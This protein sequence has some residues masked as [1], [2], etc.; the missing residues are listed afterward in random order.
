VTIPPFPPPDPAQRATDPAPRATDPEPLPTTWRAPDAASRATEAPYGSLDYLPDPRIRWGLWAALV[1]VLVFP[2]SMGILIVLV[3]TGIVPI[4]PLTDLLAS[5]A[6]YLIGAAAVVA[7]VR[8]RG[9]GSPAAD[10]GLR[11]RWIDLAIG[12]GTGIGMRVLVIALL[13]PFTPLLEDSQ[14]NLPVY[15][16]LAWTVA[17]LVV[18]GMIGAPLVEELV[19][20]GL[21]MR[22]VRN[23]MLRTRPGGALPDRRRRRLA[24]AVSVLVSTLVF[25]LFHAHQMVNPATAFTLTITTLVPGIVHA[26]LATATG[27]LGAAIVS[28]ATF[29]GS[30]LVLLLLAAALGA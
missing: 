18:V 26:V 17:T 3:L 14:G 21:V 30:A 9:S 25:V 29:N 10:L 7:I 2:L 8:L 16:D 4:S 28:H 19:C 13:V 23:R 20:R 15:D 1:G 27:R 6:V 22:A 5:S 11:F 12:F 24:I